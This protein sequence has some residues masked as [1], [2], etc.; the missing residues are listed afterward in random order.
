[1]RFIAVLVLLLLAVVPG[2][3]S[4]K[5]GAYFALG[6]GTYSCG[7]YVESKRAFRNR[8]QVYDWVNGYLS[9]YNN[10]QSDT[11]DILG[12]TDIDG[13]MVWLENHCQKHPL[14]AFATAVQR[15]VI[16]LGPKRKRIKPN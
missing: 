15:L 5:D 3:A 14:E 10:L 13:A 1:M 4:D 7:A 8:V 11:Y 2:R 9:A 16:Q 12:N 6:L